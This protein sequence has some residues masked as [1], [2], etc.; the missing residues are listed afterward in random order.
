MTSRVRLDHK[1]V[2]L[3]TATALVIGVIAA[4]GATTTAQIASYEI[5]AQDVLTISVFD[6]PSLSGKYA[7]ELDGSL[8]FPLVG[9]IKAAGLSLRDF[10]SDLRKRLAAGYFR[11]PQV[12]VA[13]EQY[14]SQ[15]IF[16]VG[17]VKDPGTYGLTGEMT[18]IEILAKA[19]STT[20]AAGDDVMI[21]RGHG[22]TTATLPEA[23]DAGDVI[24]VNLKDLQ[25]GSAGVR[26]MTL[27]DGD[28]VYV[29]RAQVVY[30]FGQVKNPGS[31]AVQSDTTVLQVLSLAGGVL[32]TGAMNRMQVIRVVS[33]AKKEF[34]V[35]PTEGVNPGDT[36]V[37][38]ERFF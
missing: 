16:V 2:W 29:P 36:I 10:E 32:P 18:L 27:S 1:A 30:V 19:G 17:A 31:Y 25:S 15:R 3:L 4:T 24:R 6:E 21:V 14:R 13:I 34:K 9:R 22:R 11:N 35:K 28:T 33:G 12:S 8:S 23:G 26:N 38:P 5:G 37:V 20:D 7:V